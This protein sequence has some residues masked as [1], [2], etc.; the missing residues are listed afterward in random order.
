MGIGDL[1]FSFLKKYVCFNYNNYY[2]YD[3]VN[4]GIKIV[5]YFLIGVWNGLEL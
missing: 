3:V 4:C 1:V 5:N 2:E